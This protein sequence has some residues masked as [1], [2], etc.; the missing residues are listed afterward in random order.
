LRIHQTQCPQFVENIACDD[1]A[2]NRLHSIQPGPKHQYLEFP[3]R[4]MFGLKTG[5]NNDRK[6]C[7]SG[8]SP[9]N[10]NDLYR[11]LIRE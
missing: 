8:D 6:T 11:L 2:R 3:V 9:F 1:S 7:Y 4:I 5:V 10:V